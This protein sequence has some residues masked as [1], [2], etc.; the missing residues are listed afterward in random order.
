M[1]YLIIAI[2]T[3]GIFRFLVPILDNLTE[4]FNHLIAKATNKYALD[5]KSAQEEFRKKYDTELNQRKIGFV[6][7]CVSYDNI[8]ESEDYYEEDYD[9]VEDSTNKKSRKKLKK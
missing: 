8:K 6:N 9:D 2:A 4:L 1:N 5:I 3:L 7:D